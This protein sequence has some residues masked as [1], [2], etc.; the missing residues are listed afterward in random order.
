MENWRKKNKLRESPQPGT[1][2]HTIYSINGLFV[3]FRSL[4][5]F[6]FLFFD[7]WLARLFCTLISRRRFG[8]AVAGNEFDHFRRQFRR[9]TD[10]I[11]GNQLLHFEFVLWSSFVFMRLMRFRELEHLPDTSN[12]DKYKNNENNTVDAH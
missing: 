7:N 2:K 3:R 10:Q 4:Q 12:I 8:P 9:I 1:V 6:I 11:V 5:K